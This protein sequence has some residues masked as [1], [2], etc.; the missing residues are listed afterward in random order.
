MI[1]GNGMLAKAFESYQKRQ[2]IIIFAS[3]VSDSQ[4]KNTREFLREKDL[5]I[6]NLEQFKNKKFIY[7]STC[8]IDDLSMKESLYIH[9]KLAMENIIS[10]MHPNY[11]I[12]R[13]PQVIGKTNSPTIIHY[14]YEKIITGKHFE[15]WGNSSRNL[16]DVDDIVKIV[17][18]IINH[19]LYINEITNIAST[20]SLEVNKIVNIIEALCSKKGNYTIVEKGIKYSINIDKIKSLLEKAE[21]DFKDNYIAKAILKYYHV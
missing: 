13:L 17:D 4:Q 9:H 15:L 5:L 14:L 12:F 10:E 3:G 11:H 2:D 7:F 6:E 20:Q 8:S 21:I 1:I 19:D 18:L 16:I